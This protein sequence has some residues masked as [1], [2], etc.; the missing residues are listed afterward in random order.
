M[1]SR[2]SWA[3]SAMGARVVEAA[4]ERRESAARTSSRC[5]TTKRRSNMMRWFYPSPSPLSRLRRLGD[6][7][8]GQGALPLAGSRAGS[9]RGVWG[10]APPP[11]LICSNLREG[12][13]VIIARDCD[14]IAVFEIAA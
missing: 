9:P 7:H 13:P 1:S 8:K 11:P 2:R 6:A 10:S 4:G 12:Q 5:S 14:G 3:S